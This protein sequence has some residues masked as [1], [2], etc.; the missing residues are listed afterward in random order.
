MPSE[1]GDRSVQINRDAVGNTIIT[2]DHN[3]VVVYQVRSF[4]VEEET[5]S[6]GTLSDNPYRGLEAFDVGDSA[7]F[8][9]RSRE[10]SDLWDK[11]Q[12]IGTTAS[13]PRPLGRI[14][15]IIGPSGSGKSSL[16]RA[17]LIAELV[18]R[19]WPGRSPS[20]VAVFNPGERPLEALSAAMLRAQS[21][22][23]PNI[24]EVRNLAQQIARSN[25]NGEYDG[26]R[27]LCSS[28]ADI[29]RPI[30]LLIDQF[31][32]VF[33]ICEDAD[34]RAAFVGNL[35][36]AA[37]DNA[38]AASVVLTLRSDFLPHTQRVDWLSEA[39]TYNGYII[40]KM[41][42]TAL[43]SA[44]SEPAR[45][46][47]FSFDTATLDLLVEQTKGRDGALPLLQF[48]LSQI[49]QGLT[50]TPSVAPA[51]TL[52]AIGGV[53]GALAGEAQRQLDAL[54]P[55]DKAIA[56]R[57]FISGVHLE[58][59]A[60][61]TRRRYSVSEIVARGESR[62]NVLKV[63]R[64]F[65]SRDARL[66]TLST[67]VQDPDTQ[68]AITHETLISAWP[69]LK[70]WV[71]KTRAD[72][73]FHRQL[74]EA[75]NNW[76]MKTGAS[77][78]T[79]ELERLREFYKRA[80]NDLTDLEVEFYQASERQH[81]LEVFLKRAALA[82]LL[83][84][85]VITSILAAWALRQRQQAQTESVL[86]R[87][88]QLAA[89]SNS[90]LSLYPL[91]SLLLAMKAMNL[92]ADTVSPEQALRDALGRISGRGLGRTASSVK[93]VYIAADKRWLVVKETEGKISLHSVPSPPDST[94]G[95]TFLGYGPEYSDLDF[96]SDRRWLLTYDGARTLRLWDFK[97]RDLPTSMTLDGGQ[98]H[99]FTPDS[100]WFALSSDGQVRLWSLTSSP[101]PVPTTAPLEA[102][103][104][105]LVASNASI[106]VI[107][108][109]GVACEIKLSAPGHAC[110]Q[111]VLAGAAALERVELSNNGRVLVGDVRT[112]DAAWNGG[113]KIAAWFL[114]PSSA[115]P[116]TA[117]LVDN[118]AKAENISISQDSQ[119]AAV[120]T[121]TDLNSGNGGLIH[122]CRLAQQASPC[123]SLDEHAG[124][125]TGLLFTNDDKALIST[126]LDGTTRVWNLTAADPSKNPLIL[127]GHSGAVNSSALDPAGRWL[128][129]GG[130]DQNLILWDMKAGDIAASGSVFRGME[131]ALSSI[132]FSLDSSQI[133]AADDDGDIRLWDLKRT[134]PSL[135]PDIV[136]VQLGHEDV[137]SG[138][139]FTQ[140]MR[141]AL[142]Y[143]GENG[144]ILTLRRVTPDQRGDDPILIPYQIKG[145][146]LDADFSTDSRWLAVS[147]KN[148][149]KT[150]L[151]DLSTDDPMHHEHDLVGVFLVFNRHQ[152]F[153][154]DHKWIITFDEDGNTSTMNL[155]DITVSGPPAR[156]QFASGH[157]QY[158]EPVFS[159]DGKWLVYSMDGV[160][161]AV[162]LSAA[163]PELADRS[164]ADGI[165]N[166]SDVWFTPGNGKV[167]YISAAKHALAAV[168]L[169]SKEAPEI[170]PAIS[171]DIQAHVSPDRILLLASFTADNPD[172]NYRMQLPSRHLP[173]HLQLWKWSGTGY[174]PSSSTILLTGKLSSTE[175]SPK[176]RWLVTASEKD[177]NPTLW[178]LAS[179]DPFKQG[180]ELWGHTV[181]YNHLWRVAFSPDER[182]LATAGY[183]DETIRIWDLGKAQVSGS[184]TLLQGR[185]APLHDFSFSPD[186]TSFVAIDTK[187]PRLW[188]IDAKGFS[189]VPVSMGDVVADEE[190]SAEGSMLSP[191]GDELATWGG[192]T[193]KFWSLRLPELVRKAQIAAGRNFTW[194]EWARS[195]PGQEYVKL[196]PR[197][198]VDRSVVSGILEQ[199]HLELLRHNSKN[200]RHLYE[201]ALNWSEELG[202]PSA[203]NDVAWKGATDNMAVSVATAGETA[204][205]TQPGNGEYRDTR[206]LIRALTGNF[207]GAIADYDF[208][209]Q[210]ASQMEDPPA[211]KIK[212][213]QTW[214]KALKSGSNP[215]NEA[216]LSSLRD[217]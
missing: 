161:H 7:R 144:G 183:D 70:D 3:T 86:A 150:N 211:A 163:S 149:N 137:E 60:R 85:V 199:A 136:R 33:S 90:S 74:A 22:N 51:D 213:R 192:E 26:L 108:S 177:T 59:T 194:D 28:A 69:A 117:T 170:G 178:D 83:L 203:S 179:A 49:W 132:S 2:G 73:R 134:L 124:G 212:K 65:S 141:W 45:R 130:A 191:Q 131:A 207:K 196:F 53:G 114:Q 125:V 91:R 197:L 13:A 92:G 44:I 208:Y 56:R 5:P 204:V 12:S 17:G 76:K 140:D 127:R 115:T 133:A 181:K 14:L 24:D 110:R 25:S 15:P 50:Q 173:A 66:L 120:T 9:G 20:R 198:P 143:E 187:G 182:W 123:F 55:P 1:I 154:P 111:T 167:A 138:I 151:Y 209:L 180:T 4:E 116:R 52:R 172:E 37:L 169:K 16:A 93:Q 40:P 71:T 159:A 185:N 46:G 62:E 166:F 87:A 139:T 8:F 189:D 54:S 193:V 106:V 6:T 217:E 152:V 94:A 39:V 97:N 148:V 162:D 155:W 78:R 214:E 89:E 200:A 101:S 215:F 153:S 23:V 158:N 27:I 34:Q 75:A 164:L 129:T 67:T 147:D 119:W 99:A 216:L 175:F 61:D 72:I 128:A 18:R 103:A 10:I 11:L 77:W 41:D 42:E 98:T 102:D 195:F 21:T 188:R 122:L 38:G 157:K 202:D 105:A 30:V 176:S 96:S 31:E 100:H 174:S 113:H 184:V 156:H 121:G 58:E 63:L 81:R 112:R 47:G 29:S 79:P 95:T 210:W 36:L 43:R 107:M 165:G 118:V 126:S 48:A 201:I 186:T 32:E 104:K 168:D 80:A 171:G 142:T 19:P 35:R 88:H 205:R 190:S 68:V 146:L 82:V 206:A 135:D 84:A 160:L 64:R 109:N 57:A 145:Y